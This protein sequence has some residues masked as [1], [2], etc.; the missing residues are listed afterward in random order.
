MPHRDWILADEHSH[1]RRRRRRLAVSSG[2]AYPPVKLSRREADRL[3]GRALRR[4][5]LDTREGYG[6]SV[7]S[8]GGGAPRESK[9][10]WRSPTQPH[11]EPARSA[12]RT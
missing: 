6:P 1:G 8:S 10:R 5:V 9:K 11:S 4:S 12:K 3:V 2:R 7:L